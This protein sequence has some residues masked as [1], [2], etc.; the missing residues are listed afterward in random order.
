MLVYFRKARRDVTA[1][2]SS[3]VIFSACTEAKPMAS[4]RVKHFLANEIV[5]AN[6]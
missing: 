1:G 5:F 6:K 2:C 3:L 4:F